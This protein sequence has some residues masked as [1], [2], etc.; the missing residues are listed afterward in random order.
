VWVQP[1]FLLRNPGAPALAAVAVVAGDS[2]RAAPTLRDVAA[3]GVAPPDSAELVAPGDVR[4]RARTLYESM[5]EALRRGDWRAFGA[6]FDALGALL[7][8][9]RE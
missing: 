4:A 9:G 8:R 5:R 7:G 1:V 2:A 6:A 3:P